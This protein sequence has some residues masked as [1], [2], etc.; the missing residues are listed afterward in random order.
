MSRISYACDVV[1]YS[2]F[3]TQA[4]LDAYVTHPAHLK[5]RD[6]LKGLRVARHQV[7]YEVGVPKLPDGH[8][9]AGLAKAS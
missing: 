2:E 4:S 3:D 1:L 6:A 9:M 8:S 5:V 7:D